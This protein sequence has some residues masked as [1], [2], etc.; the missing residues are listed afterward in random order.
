MRTRLKAAWK[1]YAAGYALVLP[2]LLVI[3]AVVLYPMVQ[4]IRMSFQNVTLL[5]MSRPDHAFVGLQNY[6]SVFRNPD[7]WV[8]VRNTGVWTI[9]NLVAQIV[10]GLAFALLLNQRLRLQGLFRSISLIPWIVPSVVAVLTWR[11][12][13]DANNGVINIWLS[14]L[15]IIDR[16]I[17]WLG[18]M[19]TALWAVIIES[20]W[21]GTP[22]VL[23][24]FLS[25]LQGIPAQVYEAAAIDGC[26]NLQM[27]TRI[28]IPMLRRTIAIATTLTLVYTLNN[29][30]AVWLMTQGGPLHASEIML[31]Y[32]Y[33]VAFRDFNLGNAAAISVLMFLLLAIISSF[34]IGMVEREGDL[35]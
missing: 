29:F 5:N 3:F 25:A 34:Y 23:I 1:A 22:F 14:R 28:I 8:A 24:M 31:T 32:A 11:W 9:A 12:M 16:F 4:G 26:N 30:N 10:L 15:G 27:L 35:S 6:I 33:K 19:K 17:H 13:Y 7:F 21:K 2:A 18:N 20:I